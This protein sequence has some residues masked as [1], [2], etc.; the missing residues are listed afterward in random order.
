MPTPPSGYFFYAHS[1]CILGIALDVYLI[2]HGETSLRTGDKVEAHTGLDPM[3]PVEPTV[4]WL[5]EQAELGLKLLVK[6]CGGG[7]SNP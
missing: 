6:W 5:S 4:R 7:D 1:V 2:Q 3:D